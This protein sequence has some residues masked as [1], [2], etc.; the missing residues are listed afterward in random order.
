[1]QSLTKNIWVIGCKD[2]PIES[3]SFTKLLKQISHGT[4]K[5]RKARFLVVSK[6]FIFCITKSGQ[7]RNCSNFKCNNEVMLLITAVWYMPPKNHT[8]SQ[9]KLNR[10]LYTLRPCILH[11]FDLLTPHFTVK[12]PFTIR[13]LQ[14]TFSDKKLN[15]FLLIDTNRKPDE[16]KVSSNASHQ[17]KNYALGRNKG[18]VGW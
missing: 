16:Q 7:Y 18:N 5:Q 6:S 13:S 14:Q 4:Q 8:L 1:M 10:L 3:K 2:S 9:L 12:L 17:P 11:F 15:T